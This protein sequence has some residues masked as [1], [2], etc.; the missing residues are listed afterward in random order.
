MRKRQRDRK[1]LR[2]GRE[3]HIDEEEGERQIELGKCGTETD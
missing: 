3:T 1:R 2:R